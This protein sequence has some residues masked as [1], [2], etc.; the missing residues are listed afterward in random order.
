MKKIKIPLILFGILIVY[1][2]ALYFAKDITEFVYGCEDGKAALSRAGEFGDSAGA[3]NALFSALA[4]FGVLWTLLIQKADSKEQEKSIKIDRFENT[5]FQMLG[6]QQDIVKDLYYSYDKDISKRRLPAQGGVEVEEGTEQ[7]I[8]VGRELFDFVYRSIEWSL[9]GGGVI[10]GLINVIKSMGKSSYNDVYMISHFDHYF[11]HLYRIIKYVD[12]TDLLP[13][14]FD[15]RYQ[16]T[17]IVRAQLSP[18]EL[19]FLYYN[20]LVGKGYEK[21]KP[22]VE[23]YSLLKNIRLEL[24]AE[25]ED[26]V[27][28]GEKFKKDYQEKENADF[29]KEYRKS[30]FVPMDMPTKKYKF[31]LPWVLDINIKYYRIQKKI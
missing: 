7:R 22:L 4:F 1:F 14:D 23:K 28:Y 20:C 8:I 6:L 24:L 13:N 30:S 25:N 12:E 21:F 27:L 2:L 3:I 19:I 17:S 10:Q 31:G 5:F 18:Y 26:Q 11:R 9:D 15:K 16:Y 29:T